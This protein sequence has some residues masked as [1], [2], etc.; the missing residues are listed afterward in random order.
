MPENV[1]NC[2][3]LPCP[4]PVIRTKKWLETEKPAQ[5][6]VIVDNEPALENVSRFL[7]SQGYAASHIQ[8]GALWHITGLRGQAPSSPE[9]DIICP[10]DDNPA[11]Q[12]TGKTL[13]MV[14]APVFG[15][16]DDELG[17]R[18]MK[19]FLA[20]LPELGPE[21]WRL[22]FVNGGVT[23]TAGGSHVLE[24]IQRLARAGISVLVCGTCLEHYGLLRD[25]AVGDTTN[26]LDI[27]TSMQLADKVLRV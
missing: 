5:L 1:L 23:L 21:L 12:C 15:Q 17:A 14:S 19:N 25:K 9:P 13:I 24:D 2:Q 8:K 27:V 6:I 22:V 16:G 3:N 7:A 10:V 20:T 4:E 11:R 18:L 26:M